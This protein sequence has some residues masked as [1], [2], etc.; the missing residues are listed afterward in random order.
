MD[1]SMGTSMSGMSMVFFTATDTPLFSSAWTPQSTGQYA[2]TCIFLIVLSVI[3]RFLHAIHTIFE[4]RWLSRSLH[5]RDVVVE[6]TSET[7]RNKVVPTTQAASPETVLRDSQ[8]Y[9]K[10]SSDSSATSQSGDPPTILEPET[11]V[12]ANAALLIA[13]RLKRPAQP[14]RLSVDLPRALLAVVVA[15]V[16]YLLCVFHL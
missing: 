13:S 11:V 16:G 15:G 14:W 2:A 7:W 9:T 10:F 1:M 12:A 5:L 3:F 6:G 4:R 8:K